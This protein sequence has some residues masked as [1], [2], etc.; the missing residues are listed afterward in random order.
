MD[1][2]KLIATHEIVFEFVY[3]CA[4]TDLFLGRSRAPPD[5]FNNPPDTAAGPVNVFCPVPDWRFERA[6]IQSQDSSGA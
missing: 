1:K 6:I 3:D 2:A 5:G 4:R